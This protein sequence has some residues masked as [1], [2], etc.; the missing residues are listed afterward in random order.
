MGRWLRHQQARNQAEGAGVDIGAPLVRATM[1][2]TAHSGGLALDLGWCV[3][4]RQDAVFAI[5]HPE[6]P[7][8]RHPR[9][10]ALARRVGAGLWAALFGGAEKDRSEPIST[11][12]S[13]RMNA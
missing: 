1:A 11:K 12:A 7:F 3:L 10:Q 6:L 5:K 8:L 13:H 2:T 4:D 9:G